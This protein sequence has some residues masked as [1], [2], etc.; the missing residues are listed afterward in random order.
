M[1]AGAR[2]NVHQSGP[3]GGS[4][5]LF[6]HGF[7][8]DQHMWRHVAGAF[9]DEFRVV[10]FDLAG[11]GGSDLAAYDHDRYASLRGHAEDV[12]ELC[13]ELG[14]EAVTFVGHSVSAMIGVLAAVAEP[15]RFARLVLVGPSPR[16]T[17]VDDY[18][19]GFSAEDIEGAARVAGRQL[20]GLGRVDGSGDHGERGSARP[21]A[22][23]SRPASVAR[24]RRSPGT[25]HA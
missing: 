12:L 20:P 17:D 11:S 15:S 14:L 2:W 24:T 8:C 25:S 23:S 10:L 7:G 5:L 1:D 6:A 16:Y 19:G 4:V 3:E 9:E 22:P 18:R 13:D 21:W